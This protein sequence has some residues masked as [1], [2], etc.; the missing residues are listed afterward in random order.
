MTETTRNSARESRNKLL[1]Q[2]SNIMRRRETELTPKYE[3]TEL[4]Q[5][6][7]GKSVSIPHTGSTLPLQP[8]ELRAARYAGPYHPEKLKI[9]CIRDIYT[10]MSSVSAF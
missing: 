8:N 9:N 7:E 4:T 3:Q 2:A 6:S 5:N 1:Q 10:L